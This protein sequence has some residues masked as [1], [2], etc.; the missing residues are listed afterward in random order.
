MEKSC[1][2]RRC[3]YC[4]GTRCL[5]Y[6]EP[7]DSDIK[8]VVMFHALCGAKGDFNLV[9]MWEAIGIEPGRPQP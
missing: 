7:L 6:D 2:P 4:I 8:K 1:S 5:K 9:G 3:R